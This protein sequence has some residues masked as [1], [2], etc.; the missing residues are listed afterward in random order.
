MEAIFFWINFVTDIDTDLA[1]FHLKP[2]K[3]PWS[4]YWALT[5]WH[6]LQ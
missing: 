4:M 3:V 5:W 6:N 1:Q 2:L